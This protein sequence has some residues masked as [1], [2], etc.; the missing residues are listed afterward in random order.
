M[1]EVGQERP[2]IGYGSHGLSLRGVVTLVLAVAVTTI[3][4]AGAFLW[5]ERQ[6]ILDDAAR[7]AVEK[8]DLLAKHAEAV[9]ASIDG[10]FDTV[11]RFVQQGQTLP[12][13]NDLDAVS[14]QVRNEVVRFYAGVVADHPGVTGLWVLDENGRGI[15]SSEGSAVIGMDLSDRHYF[16][17]VLDLPPGEIFVAHSVIARAASI[18]GKRISVVSR[19]IRDSE[20]NGVAVMAVRLSDDLLGNMK[21]AISSFSD[22][23]IGMYLTD[24]SFVGGIPDPQ[25]DVFHVERAI[26]DVASGLTAA[27]PV[28][29]R[30]EDGV[31][32]VGAV[33]RVPSQPLVVFS[34]VSK[35]AILAAKFRPR[36]FVTVFIVGFLLVALL[37]TT[38]FAVESSRDNVM[39]RLARVAANTAA[40]QREQHTRRILDSLAEAVLTVDARGIVVNA[41]S[42][43]GRVFD[44]TRSRLINADLG[45]L[46]AL[47]EGLSLPDRLKQAAATG[48]GVLHVM[49]VEGF[50][51]QGGGFPAD[52]AIAVFEDGGAPGFSVIVRDRTDHDRAERLL[53]QSGKMDAIGRLAGGVAH[54]FNNLL[55]IILGNLEIAGLDA[56]DRQK[57]RLAACNRAASRAAD[58]TRKLLTF[59]RTQPLTAET[60]DLNARVRE[61]EPLLQQPLQGHWAL[62]L[63]LSKSPARVSVDPGEFEDAIL[64]LVLNARDASP[65]GGPIMVESAA[66]TVGTGLANTLGVEPG[67]Y[68]VVS[69]SDHGIGL[70]PKERDRIFEPFYTTKES[71]TGLGLASVYG[72]VRRSLGTIRVYSEA[73]V[74]TTVKI[75]LPEAAVEEGVDGV[76]EGEDDALPRGH[77]ETVLVVDDE[78]DL[79]DVAELWLQELGY[80]TI[81]A[82]TAAEAL[83]ILRDQTGKIDLLFTDIV[84][85][86]G[87]NGD[88]LA[89]QALE[90]HT[91]LRV[92]MAS[93]FTWTAW[94]RE[95]P[96]GDQPFPMLQKPY[97]RHD[98]ATII[99]SGL[100]IGKVVV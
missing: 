13:L 16:Q 74:G 81:T 5:F 100:A 59:S 8:T 35:D 69:V 2:V 50:R 39:E 43:A 41:N 12:L 18:R 52:L 94:S 30:L 32:R 15:A 44:A 53:R 20:G 29:L 91:G 72:F 4:T 71:G 70:A 82:A 34:G 3:L 56:S 58:L 25:S 67:P 36:V 93:G 1:T 96:A 60:V 11:E 97:R 76:L 38:R 54:D 78:P 6:R 79:R 28:T 89:R 64:N 80:R 87:T 33:A 23:A 99:A 98:L 68:M 45:R 31:E 77:G 84:L 75:I 66:L 65:D 62:E 48:T 27:Q 7:Q 88:Q 40:K 19:V 22:A 37:L 63:H 14:P 10:M 9:Y 83:D 95:R 21:G 49:K 86:G 90:I 73:G 47:P 46:V 42:A 24:G 61:I 51:R 92:V 55:G 17:R 57:P 26:A 85:P